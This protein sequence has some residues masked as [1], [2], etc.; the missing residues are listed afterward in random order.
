MSS[1]SG[2][3]RRSSRPATGSTAIGSISA[4]PSACVDSMQR[5]IVSLRSAGARALA[6]WRARTRAVRA[7]AAQR[8]RVER[9]HGA[10]DARDRRG[11]GGD[12]VHAQADEDRHGAPRSDRKRAAHRDFLAGRVRRASRPR[13]MRRSTAGCSASSL[14]GELRMRRGPS[15]ACTATGRWCRSRGSRLRA[16]SWSASSA[17]AG[18]SIITPSAGSAR[19]RARARIRR[20]SARTARSSSTSVTIGSRMRHWPAASRAGSRAAACAA[21][22]AATGSCARRAGRARGCPRAAAAGRRSA[23]RRRCRA[24]GS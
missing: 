12:L 10:L 4:R 3:P 6:R 7:S 21:A 15:R 20:A 1:R 19:C 13:A 22:P 9:A 5:F 24:C 23:C 11:H 17:E 14:R 2:W 18:V 16:A 8:A